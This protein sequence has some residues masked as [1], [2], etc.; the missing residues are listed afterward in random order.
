MGIDTG[1]ITTYTKAQ[2]KEHDAKLAEAT[3]A[4]HAAAGRVGNAVNDIHR[5]VGDEKR[6]VGGSRQGTWTMTFPAAVEA[7]QS[8]VGAH[9]A[10]ASQLAADALQA[11]QTAMASVAAAREVVRQLDEVWRTHGKWNRFFMVPGGH[12]HSSTACHS[13]HVSTQIGWLP[14]L[15]GE[16][17]AEAVATYGTVLC[18]KCFPT[19]PVE[20]TTKAPNPVDPNLCPGSNNYVPG[21]NLRLCSPRGT[22]P[23]CGQ[24]GISVTK[25][26]LARKHDRP[27]TTTATDPE[28]AAS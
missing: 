5:T 26:G 13:L 6:Y 25:R 3:K 2:A 17:E 14:D 15:S 10:R 9:V 7:A 8:V 16:S 19:A 27:K 1:D 12:I 22:C 4:L 18:T 21:A 24:T 28:T 23:E 20:W 11:H